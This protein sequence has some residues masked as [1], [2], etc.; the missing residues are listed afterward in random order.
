[1]AYENNRGAHAIYWIEEYCVVPS[2]PDKGKPVHL[3]M[4][5]QHV[6]RYIYDRLENSRLEQP[7]GGPVGAYL[8]LL[9]TCGPEAKQQRFRPPIDVDLFTT[10]NAAG[11]HLREVLKREGEHILC[12]QLDTSYPQVAA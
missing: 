11:P 8:A 9:H 6:V 10:W 3:T 1:M 5:E 2:G 4:Q 7:I 12:P